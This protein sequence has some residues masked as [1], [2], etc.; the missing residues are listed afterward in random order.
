MRTLAQR[1]GISASTISD[2]ERGAKSP[3]IST[4][5]SLA[6][7][8]GVPLSALVDTG[9]PPPPRRIR[10]TRGA[11]RPPVMDPVTGAK[12]ESFGPAP[13]ESKVEFLRYAV[14]PRTTAGPFVAHAA[15][16]IEHVHL[17]AGSVRVVFGDEAVSLDAGD[18][19]SGLADR[20]HLFD[21]ADGDVEA[22]IYLVIEGR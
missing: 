16:T 6:E 17:A 20:P 22:L 9:S 12:R 15:G 10:V 14:P 21:N 19:C 13:A 8:L 7:A 1:S 2:I 5:S 11:E 3:T 18:S 4:L